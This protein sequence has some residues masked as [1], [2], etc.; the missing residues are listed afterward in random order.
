M[1]CFKNVFLASDLSLGYVFAGPLIANINFYCG[2]VS[3]KAAVWF[4]LIKS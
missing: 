4:L 3:P 1:F 2:Q